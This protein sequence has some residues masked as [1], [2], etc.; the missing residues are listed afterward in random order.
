[1]TLESL[2]LIVEIKD[3]FGG[4]FNKVQ[5][6]LTIFGIDAQDKEKRAFVPVE[7]IY[8][9]LMEHQGPAL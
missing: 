6:L 8:T 1:M 5:M 4:V 9:C 2:W 7:A 3:K